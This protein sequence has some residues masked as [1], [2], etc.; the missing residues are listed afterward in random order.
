MIVPIKD[1]SS[2]GL[3][4][5]YSPE[6]LS[7]EPL[8]FTEAQNVRFKNGV[9]SKLGGS[10]VLINNT[11][12]NPY[13]S[14]RVTDIS[15]TSYYLYGGLN[16]F[17]MYSNGTHYNITRQTSGSD[18]NYSCDN[19]HLWT[20]TVLNGFPIFNNGVDLPQA[21]TTL[22][23]STKLTNLAGMPSTTRCGI[24]RAFKAYLIAG[25]I[26]EGSTRYPTRVLWS[27]A[28][29]PGALP[30]SWDPTD[31][32]SDCGYIDLADSEGK[33]I[34][35][36]IL[37]DN[38]V[39]YKNTATYVMQYI[40]GNKIFAI[41]KSFSNVGALSKNCI[42]EVNGQ[43]LVLTNDDV[44]LTDGFQY[45]SIADTRVK[46]DLFAGVN[47]A[48]LLRSY[49]VPNYRQSEVWI[50][51][52]TGSTTFPNLVY[53]YNYQ[54]NVW[55]TRTMTETPSITNGFV[56]VPT[57]GTYNSYTTTIYNNADFSYNSSKFNQTSMLLT[58][59]D[60][61]NKKL[62]LMD[63]TVNTDMGIPMQ[64]VLERKN[65][66]LTEDE[67]IKTIKRIYPKMMVDVGSPNTVVDFYIG[68][69]MF[70][71]DAIQWKG[72]FQYNIQNKFK[73]DMFATGRF[74]SLRIRSNVD[75]G[76]SLE[77]LEIEFSNAGKW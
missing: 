49:I 14:T 17:Y 50:C 9:V 72:P 77:N 66:S 6:L 42:A 70:K 36:K 51:I 30:T 15:G 2:V 47:S 62:I 10:E 53:I 76:W 40:G 46:Q 1:I 64:V 16:K 31:P 11:T 3:I 75:I 57:V 7:S 65:I 45:K 37:G 13:Y 12:I 41:K 21:W 29:A 38:L 33:I 74:I 20:H 28:A 43:H 58:S 8:A 4:K 23:T 59:C 56:D 35:M 67:T 32:T 34:D 52:P 19:D 69:Q 68:V 24:M 22:N 71:N 26:T 18:V 55:S 48:A 25:N 60:H 39:I 54:N 5:D 63:S 61:I 27:G 73:I 44:I